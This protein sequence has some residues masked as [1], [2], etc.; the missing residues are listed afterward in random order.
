[1]RKTLAKKGKLLMEWRL[2]LSIF[3]V[4]III[5]D[6]FILLCS[7]LNNFISEAIRFILFSI[8]ILI[9]SIVD[10]RWLNGKPVYSLT[11]RTW[12]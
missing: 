5:S 12:M 8:V 7:Y 4:I 11:P 6:I 1:M 3:F 10:R 2:G 9:Y